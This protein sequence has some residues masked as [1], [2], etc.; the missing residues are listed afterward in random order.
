MRSAFRYVVLV[1]FERKERE[2]KREERDVV[3]GVVGMLDEVGDAREE[4][5]V[6]AIIC[7]YGVHSFGVV[8]ISYPWLFV[9]DTLY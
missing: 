1:F 8:K 2:E 5:L 3:S 9:S 6:L 7:M 4:R